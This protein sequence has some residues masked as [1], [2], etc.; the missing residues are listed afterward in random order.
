MRKEGHTI[1]HCAIL[2]SNNN[3]CEF[4]I[5][6]FLLAAVVETNSDREKENDRRA[7]WRIG[8]FCPMNVLAHFDLTCLSVEMCL[9]ISPLRRLNVNEDVD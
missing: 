8:H 5:C 1:K 2:V 7:I 4:C 3:L 9:I 6:D